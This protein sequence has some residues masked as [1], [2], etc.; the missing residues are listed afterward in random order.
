MNL[1]I[2]TTNWSLIYLLEKDDQIIA[3]YEKRDIKKISDIAVEELKLF[4]A[5][6]GLTVRNIENI[7]VTTGPGSYT[8]VRIGLA[9]AKTLKTLNNDYNVF[10]ANSLMFQAGDE[11]TISLLDARGNKSY[12]G[13]YKNSQPLINETV[14]TNNELPAIFKQYP[15]MKVIRDYENISFVKNYLKL[16]NK[17]E[18]VKNIAD[19]NPVYIKNF[20]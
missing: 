20:I 8:G 2:D 16:K 18:E 15:E 4:L 12:L 3:S 17:F 1:F 11:P 9:V 10:V 19:L 6:E 5:K 7:Y 14:V 13:I